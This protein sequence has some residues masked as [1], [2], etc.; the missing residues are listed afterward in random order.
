[1][2]LPLSQRETL[3]IHS[4]IWFK[5]LLRKRR[6]FRDIYSLKFKCKD[7]EMMQSY[8]KMEKE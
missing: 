5:I 1:M 7:V 3:S 2:I 8:K 4:L 6:L